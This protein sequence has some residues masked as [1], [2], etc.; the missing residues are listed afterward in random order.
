M[1]I[2]ASLFFVTLILGSATTHALISKIFNRDAKIAIIGAGPAG[3]ATAA[4]LKQN[5][6]NDVTIY[7]RSARAFG[8]VRTEKIG[9]SVVEMGPIQVGI[10]HI[11]TSY[12][13]EKLGL[14]TF[15]PHNAFI[16]RKGSSE[17]S[18]VKLT[19]AQEYFPLGQRIEIMQEAWRFSNIIQEFNEHYPQLK[20]IPESSDYR[21]SFL[22]FSKKHNLP[23]FLNMYSIYTSAYGYGIVS[24]IPAFTVLRTFGASFGLVAWLYAG[25]NLKMIKEGFSGLMQAL[26]DHHALA[27]K[28]KYNQNI[29]S[30]LRI[31]GRPVIITSNNED[32]H[33]DYLIVACPI[34]K[35]FNAYDKAS[36]EEKES[37]ENL[38]YS[39]YHV[40]VADV[41]DLPRGGFVLPE[42]FNRH[43]TLQMLS[44][45]SEQGDQVVFYIPQLS[46]VR[47]KDML[48]NK[49]NL[50]KLADSINAARRDLEE[51]GFHMGKIYHGV[52]WN[53]Y[54]P[55]FLNPQ[56]YGHG[57]SIQGHNKTFYVGTMWTEIDYVDKAFAHAHKITSQFFDGAY[58]QPEQ[59]LSHIARWYL[60]AEDNYTNDQKN[61]S[62][63]QW[64]LTFQQWW[65]DK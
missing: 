47:A 39:P 65:A 25:M 35:I 64:D 36:Q 52:E 49:V 19:S 58:D 10:G 40:F 29:S 48:E 37:Y 60:G 21:L 53:Q 22:A 16:L 12:W 63:D 6:Y 26:V 38:Y 11:Y 8:K 33:Y 54:N 9:T 59:N 43:G 4:L 46:S 13:L 61:R 50:P 56:F 31:P 3:L 42:K 41:D 17:H 24:E 18:H 44:K 51:L 2:F 57:D 15:E 20:D 1:Q 45:N 62:L 14:N 27:D 32:K 5:G 30:I 55:H 23:Y 34:D 7:E 28:I